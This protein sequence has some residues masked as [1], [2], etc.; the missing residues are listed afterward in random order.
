MKKIILLL[1]FF[2]LQSNILA[3]ENLFGSQFG[4]N[5]FYVGSEIL[6]YDVEG[7]NGPGTSPTF[8]LKPELGYFFW[9]NIGV[10]AKYY[11]TNG[12]G[13]EYG[14]GVMAT[15]PTFYVNGVYKDNDSEDKHW[16]GTM[17]KLFQLSAPSQMYLNLGLNFSLYSEEEEKQLQLMV[18]GLYFGIAFAF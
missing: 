12:S 2:V 18:E 8:T 16:Q 9:D 14:L 17:G 3:Q 6:Q 13:E 10:F 15:F 5:T 11:R 7:Q 1:I 4:R